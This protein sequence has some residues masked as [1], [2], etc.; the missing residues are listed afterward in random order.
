MKTLVKVCAAIAGAVALSG[1]QSGGLPGWS[2]K[3]HSRPVL[4]TLRVDHAA[5]LEEG[6]SQLKAG[7]LSAAAASFRIASRSEAQAAEASNGLAVVYAR[8][9]RPDL[10]ERYFR[11]ALAI[12]PDSQR[13]AANLLR[14]Q[15]RILAARRMPN[16][17]ALADASLTVP[18]AASV[19]PQPSR[20]MPG[21]LER[22]ARGMVRIK[23][24]LELGPAPRMDIAY[25]HRPDLDKTETAAADVSQ[26]EAEVAVA[27]VPDKSK[28]YPVRIALDP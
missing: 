11:A 8:I 3:S 17:G 22:V 26:T 2:F 16:A 20:A 1:C 23:T 13:F 18:A 14:L 12:E 9:G 5:I 6:R 4:D 24:P 19:R 28:V 21:Q 15:G 10:A 27:A 25:R 7:N